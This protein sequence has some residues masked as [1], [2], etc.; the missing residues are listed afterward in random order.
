MLFPDYLLHYILKIH[1]IKS[2]SHWEKRRVKT[3]GPIYGICRPTSSIHQI[4]VQCRRFF[5]DFF[6]SI[7]E[8]MTLNLLFCVLMVQRLNFS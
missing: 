6:S 2:R 7:A 3:P 8:W 5:V 4:L 1:N